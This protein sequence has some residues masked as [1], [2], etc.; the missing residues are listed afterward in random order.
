MSQKE[1]KWMCARCAHC[2]SKEYFSSLLPLPS[3]VYCRHFFFFHVAA[4]LTLFFFAL[5]FYSFR[6][7]LC[8]FLLLLVSLVGFDKWIVRFSFLIG[9]VIFQSSVFTQMLTRARLFYIYPNTHTHINPVNGA[10]AHT[11][12][13]PNQIIQKVFQ[14]VRIHG[15]SFVNRYACFNH[16]W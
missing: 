6:V 14:C 16:F 10:Q 1:V 12:T 2:D 11:I 8:R 3:T 13:H 7:Y 5:S 15:K 9:W 4:S